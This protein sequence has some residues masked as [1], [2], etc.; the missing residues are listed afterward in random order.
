MEVVV[1]NI[2]TTYTNINNV[3]VLNNFGTS[4]VEL[5]CERLEA[6]KVMEILRK[7]GRATKRKTFGW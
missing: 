7:K 4:D 6:V 1:Y 2:D 3:V 5:I